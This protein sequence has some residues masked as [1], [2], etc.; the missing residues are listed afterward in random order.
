MNRRN[1]FELASITALTPSAWGLRPDSDSD[2]NGFWWV[3][4]PFDL[5]VGYV[6][7]YIEGSSITYGVSPFLGTEAN[8]TP[9]VPKELVLPPENVSLSELL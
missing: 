1:F 5:K 7:G 9:P 4:L 2:R 3:S 6:I 8:K